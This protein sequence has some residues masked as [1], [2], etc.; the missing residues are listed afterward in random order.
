MKVNV[1]NRSYVKA[2]EALL[3]TGE[4]FPINFNRVKSAYNIVAVDYTASASGF[5][6]E[7]KSETDAI[8]FLLR[9]A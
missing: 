3:K 6:I 8:M 9:F 1:S 7:F 4:E 2:N 5:E